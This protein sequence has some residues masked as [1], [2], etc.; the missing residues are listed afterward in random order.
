MITIYKTE[1][2]VYCAQ[3]IKHI[4]SKQA[5]YKVI[6]I[7]DDTKLANEVAKATHSL[8]VPVVTIAPS[9]DE[10]EHDNFYVGW[11]LRKLNKFIQT[12]KGE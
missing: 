9:L 3:T 8:T 5:P 12:V 10:I 6:D 11:N 7:T 2:C 4:E 1:K